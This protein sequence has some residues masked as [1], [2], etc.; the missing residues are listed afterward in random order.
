MQQDKVF[1][2]STRGLEFKLS[3]H[4]ELDISSHFVHVGGNPISSFTFIKMSCFSHT[5]KYLM[6]KYLRKI[7][8]TKY[9]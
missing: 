6:V 2:L 3:S 4:F 5:K 8:L 1:L 9:Y 7:I